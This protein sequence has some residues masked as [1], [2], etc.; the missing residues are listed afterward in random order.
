MKRTVSDAVFPA[1]LPGWA[2]LALGLV[3][4]LLSL[5]YPR[6]SLDSPTGAYI[7]KL[8]L[9]GGVLYRDAWDLRAP[10]AYFIHALSILLLGSS[11]VAMRFFDFLWQGTT[12]L[13]T[14]L[15]ARRLL[16]APLAALTAGL[17]LTAYY[18]MHFSN[19][20]Q[21]DGYLNLPMALSL[22]ATIRAAESGRVWL[23]AAAAASLGL[24]TL[25]KVPFA[26]FGQALMIAA[27]VVQPTGLSVVLG[28]L[29]ALSMGVALPL[30]LCALY[31][32]SHGA[33]QDLWQAQF[34]FAPAYVAQVHQMTDLAH[35]VGRM[36]NPVLVPLGIMLM[37]ALIS[38][39]KIAYRP[40]REMRW[41][42]LIAVWFAA[43]LAII[44]IHGSFLLYHF[45][46]L[47][48][49]LT[50]L[51]AG[52]F[53]LG[54]QQ[55][56]GELDQAPTRVWAA[57][58]LLFFV[59]SAARG[60]SHAAFA[61]KALRSP[62]PA[63]EWKDAAML[64]QQRTS[65]EDRIFVWGNVPALYVHADRR[66]ACRFLPTAYLSVHVPGLDYRSI[67]LQELRAYRPRIFV[68]IRR[69]P[70]TPGLP[71]SMTS[72]ESFPELQAFVH[73]HYLPGE[74]HERYVLFERKPGPQ[75]E[76]EQGQRTPSGMTW[77]VAETLVRERFRWPGCA[78]RR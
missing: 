56:K 20:T 30:S 77:Q 22:Y 55:K 18:G 42:Y 49:P 43:G 70:I 66:A 6:T 34:V 50:I 13:V 11:A 60:A 64:I 74:Q 61:W 57:V 39:A 69:G 9:E 58:L 72:F 44:L 63:D 78:T 71:D 15:I 51:A 65:R 75:G 73:S 25:I 23:W 48:P 10:G 21:P 47:F 12:A 53:H 36:L 33:L 31:F 24:A 4:G 14:L 28:R 16:P 76:G 40:G 26:L 27:V 38:V 5:A 32:Y 62:L 68:L 67:C 41:F 37:L 59:A 35:V 1:W 54:F 17:Y 3:M 2:F 46:P 7:G 29:L 19:W 8:I 45:L 52:C